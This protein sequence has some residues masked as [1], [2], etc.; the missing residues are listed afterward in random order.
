M[1]NAALETRWGGGSA[2]HGPIII[3]PHNPQSDLVLRSEVHVQGFF[4][5]QR[6]E[7]LYKGQNNTHAINAYCFMRVDWRGPNV[8]WANLPASRTSTCRM[9]SF[10]GPQRMQTTADADVLAGAAVPVRTRQVAGEQA[11]AY[12]PWTSSIRGSAKSIWDLVKG[13]LTAGSAVTLGSGML[14]E[15]EEVVSTQSSLRISDRLFA[16]ECSV[17]NHTDST[18]RGNVSELFRPNEKVEF[19][20]EPRGNKNWN[21]HSDVAPGEVFGA[22][23]Y[24]MD[25]AESNLMSRLPVA[26]LV[27]ATM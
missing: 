14:V 7:Y 10:F 8:A 27:P 22:L 21:I 26:L 9:Q 15:N 17:R 1:P 2:N 5:L 13:V 25:S 16:Y 19:V 11:D 23:E 6:H 18:I 20:I 12:V 24:G 3:S 4:S